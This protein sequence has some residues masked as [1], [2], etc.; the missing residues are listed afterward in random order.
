MPGRTKIHCKT[1]WMHTQKVK[2]NK[3]FWTEE[4][5]N[6]LRKIVNQIG[7]KSWKKVATLFNRYFPDHERTNKQCRDRW[8]NYLNPDIDNSTITIQETY[9]L[10]YYWLQLGNC[11]VKIANEMERTENWVKNNWKRIM[12]KEGVDASRTSLESN[13]LLVQKIMDSLKA[14]GQV[15]GAPLP[16]IESQAEISYAEVPEEL[17]MMSS[18]VSKSLISECA[19]YENTPSMQDNPNGIE[20]QEIMDYDQ[21]MK[22]DEKN[23][24]NLNEKMMG[25]Q[26]YMNSE[27]DDIDYAENTSEKRLPGSNAQIDFQDMGKYKTTEKCP[28]PFGNSR[29]SII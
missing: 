13:K 18:E 14:T 24:T 8:N 6:I 15:S 21:E 10:C 27:S 1:K 26:V 12:K 2:T 19:S 23:T 9:K 7:T 11:W 25:N 17:E 20:I 4:E 28:S 3:S 29:R 22:E 5:D 16:V